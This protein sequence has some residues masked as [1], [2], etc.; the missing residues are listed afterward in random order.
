[1]G[2]SV[3][4]HQARYCLDQA[5]GC[6]GRQRPVD[7]RS[8]S[9]GI[10]AG[11][12]HQLHS[13]GFADHSAPGDDV[14]VAGI[15]PGQTLVHECA[16]GTRD[17][18][19]AGREVAKPAVALQLPPHLTEKEGVAARGVPKHRRSGTDGRRVART[20][21]GQV[22]RHLARVETGQV[23]AM[24]T[25]QAH[26]LGC[27]DRD[28]WGR[29]GWAV[30]MCDEEQHGQI[31]SSLDD[32]AEGTQPGLACPVEILENHDYGAVGACTCHGRDDRAQR[33]GGER[34]RNRLGRGP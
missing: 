6:R 32:V 33:D 10:Q 20:L 7:V 21:G 28:E 5:L 16:Q 8:R 19:L 24:D 22:R 3:V 17:G 11:G 26:E 31:G 13:E 27:Q 15:E 25:G 30:T 2:E 23:D 29:V 14:P 1:V 9:A 12:S 34:L 18:N 4:A